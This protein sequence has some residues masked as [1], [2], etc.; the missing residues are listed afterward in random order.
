MV[1]NL[2]SRLLDVK[3]APLATDLSLF[4]VK[5]RYLHRDGKLKLNAGSKLN[6]PL[7]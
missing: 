3:L 5:R 2:L 1:F 4:Y 6:T 7:M